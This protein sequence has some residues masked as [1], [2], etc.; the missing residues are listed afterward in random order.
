MTAG[1]KIAVFVCLAFLVFIGFWLFDF[2]PKRAEIDSL[3]KGPGGIA[4]LTAQR[5]ADKAYVE[6]IEEY[7]RQLKEAQAELAKLEVDIDTKDFIPSYLEDIEELVK[8]I[9]MSLRDW[10]FEILTINPGNQTPGQ[11][12]EGGGSAYNTYLM[13]MT[14]D[15]QLETLQTFLTTLSNKERFKKLVVVNGITMSPKTSTQGKYQ[16]LSFNIPLMAYQFTKGGA[17]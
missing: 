11:A 15:G 3:E 5:D 9:R 6:N 4:E 2:Q 14:I 13:T 16:T 1:M 7:E 17:Q 10:D 8:E 12:T